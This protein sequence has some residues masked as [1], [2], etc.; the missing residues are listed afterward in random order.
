MYIIERYLSRPPQQF[1]RNIQAFQ[2][3]FSFFSD[4]GYADIPDF[5]RIFEIGVTRFNMGIPLNLSSYTPISP[6]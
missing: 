3:S 2:L 6:E 4:K 1:S 5:L